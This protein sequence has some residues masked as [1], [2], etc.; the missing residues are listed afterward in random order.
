MMRKLMA[1]R[2][3]DRYQTPAELANDLGAVLAGKPVSVT[4][5]AVAVMP[6]PTASHPELPAIQALQRHREP[7]R[8]PEPERHLR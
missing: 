7:L 3:E 6:L 4:V 5:P 8:G 1:K 2:P